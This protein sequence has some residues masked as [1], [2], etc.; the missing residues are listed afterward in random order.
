MSGALQCLFIFPPFY[1]TLSPLGIP[2][3]VILGRVWFQHHRL[4]KPHE[5]CSSVLVHRPAFF[6]M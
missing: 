6:F 1:V 4:G 3:Y 5:W 2:G